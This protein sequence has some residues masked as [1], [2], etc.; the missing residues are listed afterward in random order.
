MGNRNEQG[1]DLS[2]RQFIKTLGGVA[3]GAVLLSSVPWLSSCTPEKLQEIKGQ[4][5]RVALIGTGSRGRYHIH[6]LLQIPHAEIIAIC[7]NYEPH[8]KL[9]AELCPNARQYK[10]YRKMLEEKDIDGVIIATPLNWH[11]RMVLDSLMAG[12][13]VFCE[14][15][16]ARTMDE[17][18]AIYDA[19]RLSDRALYFCMQRMY[20]E[21][22][23]K[24]VQMIKDGLI[25][26]VVGMRC[27][28]FRNADWRRP[29]PSPELERQINWRLY[30]E[31]SGGLM[32]ELATHQLEICTWAAGKM[33]SEVV[34][35]GDIVYWKDGREVYDSVSLTYHFSDGRKINYESLISNKFNGMEDQILGN[36]GTVDLSKGVYYLED[37]NTVYGMRQLLDNIKTGIFAAVPTAGPSWRPEYKSEYI[38]H[39]L[40]K[41]ATI[42][43]GQSMIGVDA[44]GSD[45]IVSAFC[46]SCIT[47]EK[48]RDV[49]EEA[50][51]A[52]TLCLLGNEA[53][54]KGTK[55]VFPDEY[56][57]PYMK[58]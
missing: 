58:F 39:A 55:V 6:N 50:Y 19:Y 53:M 26:D 49:V 15:A 51:C 22:Y 36:R 7:D 27:H 57:I 41:T 1:V 48:V 32:T 5:A 3:G 16:M 40:T 30:K 38:P 56:K 14:K 44:D 11:A 23:I 4:K 24:G 25:G 54:E 17:C 31:S 21:K 10:D 35:F 45:L 13:H 20:D 34:G 37:D 43:P 42:N 28:W 52:T 9:A 47:G 12:K 8:L 2:L 33:P 18:K 46:Q 29:V